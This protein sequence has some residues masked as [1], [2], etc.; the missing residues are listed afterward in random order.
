MASEDPEPRVA[1]QEEI[2]WNHN[3]DSAVRFLIPGQELGDTR[4]ALEG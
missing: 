1:D 2:V 3:E 4:E